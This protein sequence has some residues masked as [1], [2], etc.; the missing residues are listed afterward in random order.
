MGN[1]KINPTCACADTVPRH[2]SPA[3]GHY[4]ERPVE[5][6]P[7]PPL[8]L[9]LGE[10]SGETKH[11]V[12]DPIKKAHNCID[13]PELKSQS[14]CLASRFG[15]LLILSRE[16]TSLFFFNPVTRSRID[17]PYWNHVFALATFSA[18][19]TSPDCTVFAVK[20]NYC[21][22]TAIGIHTL[23]VGQK[24]A[25]WTPHA[26][27]KD[28]K[29]FADIVAAVCTGSKGLLYCVDIRGR[30]GMFDG[31]NKVWKV[32]PCKGFNRVHVPYM[33][34]FGGQIY[35]AKKGAYGG[36]EKLERLILQKGKLVWVR[37]EDLGNVAVYL[38]PYGS[39]VVPLH[40][41]GTEKRLLVANHGP[42]SKCLIYDS[43]ASSSSSTNGDCNASSNYKESSSYY[44]ESF[45][46]CYTPVWI[47]RPN[48]VPSPE[49]EEEEKGKSTD[50]VRP[51]FEFSRQD[52]SLLDLDSQFKRCRHRFC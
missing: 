34:E 47:E 16:T 24:E 7:Q 22:P 5:S 36:I 14:E 30:V 33:V 28:P 8:L 39:C 32:L 6:Q 41:Q 31:G 52:I 49:I 21:P 42:E 29:T 20:N 27:E 26:Y 43:I 11:A 12:V 15:W 10:L 1:K 2:S 40:E 35:A 45:G 19:P 9:L 4:E 25:A 46:G 13:F 48:Y 18:P 51:Q 44:V 3:I 37:A 17:L 23:T 38:G 50:H